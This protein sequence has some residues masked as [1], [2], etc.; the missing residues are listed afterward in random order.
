MHQINP[1]RIPTID[2]DTLHA[3]LVERRRLLESASAHSND[4][5][6]Q[7]LFEAVDDALARI[8]A[9]SYGLCEV[10]DEAIEID[11]LTSNP[12]ARVCLE[13]LSDSERRALEHDLSLASTIQTELLPEPDF[14]T[15]NW[16]G[17]YSYQPH[18]PVSGD[19]CDIIH[20]HDE[21]LVLFGDISGKGV[22]AALLMSHLSAIFRSLADSERSLVE[23][24]EQANRMFCEASPIGTYATLVAARFRS[25]GA[26]E[27]ANA[28]HVPPLLHNG[29]VEQ[30]PAN[31]V[32]IGL[33]C[34]SRYTSQVLQLETGNRLVLVTDGVIESVN[35]HDDE[36]GLD[37]LSDLVASAPQ[38]EPRQLVQRLISAISSFRDGH[39]AGD[40]TTLMVVRRVA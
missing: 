9:E 22:S 8:E 2:H 20:D 27:I 29:R 35:G 33:F 10:C 30:L 12:L 37:T 7:E 1:E 14:T 40:D 4:R 36:F 13:C 34:D 5:Q 19:Y 26:V 38:D 31:G 28:G 15:P 11:H 39:R 24:M 21:M 16:S 18:G 32:P 3:N 25:N 17:H 6:L 23:M